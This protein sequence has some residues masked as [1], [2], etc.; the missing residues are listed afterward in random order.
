[1]VISF[2][3]FWL[4]FWR[5]RR[6]HNPP[7]KTL[8]FYNLD[9]RQKSKIT[10]LLVGMHHRQNP[11]N[12]DKFNLVLA[13]LGMDH[14]VVNLCHLCLKQCRCLPQGKWVKGNDVCRES[15]EKKG[16][17]RVETGLRLMQHFTI[18]ADEI[19]YC[20]AALQMNTIFDR[21]IRLWPLKFRVYK[22]GK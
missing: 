3:V 16:Q 8:D 21:L 15:E 11:S 6:K 7:F 5:R 19:F 12:S 22:H 13:W 2:Q 18:F 4:Q 9:D 20:F 1:M 10:V 14:S 17:K